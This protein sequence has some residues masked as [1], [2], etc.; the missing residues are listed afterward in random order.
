M[1]YPFEHKER[2]VYSNTFLQN[3]LVEWYFEPIDEESFKVRVKDFLAEKFGIQIGGDDEVQCP[4]AISSK[5]RKAQMLFGLDVFKLSVRVDIYKGF[6][7]L[8]PLLGFGFDYLCLNG[9]QNIRG[10]VIRKIDIFPFKNMRGDNTSN[11]TLL[12][13]VF[14]KDLLS[15]I[16]I[17]SNDA[18]QSI[19]SKEFANVEEPE[20]VFIKFGFLRKRSEPSDKDVDDTMIL[21]FSADR[22][23]SMP[24]DMVEDRLLRMN[25]TLFDAFHWSVNQRIIDIMKG[26][27]L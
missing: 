23:E 25:Q 2:K 12:G 27:E 10:C 9:I 22:F 1:A 15:G 24:V 21:D 6:D 14:S 17:S 26:D 7:S 19:W 13:K 4:I 3:V 11:E 5:A 20:K 8:N 16:S 18:I